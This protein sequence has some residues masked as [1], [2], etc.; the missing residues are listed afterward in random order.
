LFTVVTLLS[1]APANGHG[2]DQPETRQV[3]AALA[4][5]AL[6]RLGARLEFNAEGN[7]EAVWME[8]FKGTD[9]ILPLVAQLSHV[10]RLYLDESDITD[11]GLIEVGKLK[12]LQV[13]ELAATKVTNVGLQHLVQLNKLTDLGLLGTRVGSAKQSGAQ[14][15][16][17][18]ARAVKV[19]TLPLAQM[20]TLR[21]LNLHGSGFTDA[22]MASLEPLVNLE[23]LDLPQSI[24]DAGMAHLKPLR[25]LRELYLAETRVTDKGLEHLGNH[26]NLEYITLYGTAVTDAGVFKLA[27]LKSLKDVVL[28]R[29]QTTRAGV[30]ALQRVRP[31]ITIQWPD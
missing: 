5:A 7:V 24:S 13:L 31:G 15:Q 8:G 29:T 23:F 12:N 11:G 1:V 30:E 10:R 9:A 16:N 26:H 3:S 21:F 17:T 22:D 25:N 20:K 28:A 18:S 19:G 6:V 4:R 14:K 27:G 2:A